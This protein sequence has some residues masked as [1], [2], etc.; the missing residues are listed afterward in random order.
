MKVLIRSDLGEILRSI[1]D[2]RSPPFDQL[3]HYGSDSNQFAQLR[4]PNGKGPSPLL[5]VVH[6]G[7]WQSVYDL[8]HIGH[9]CAALTS[10]GVIT[11]SIEYRRIG[12][13]GGGWPGT[14]Q[15]ISLATRNILQKMSND[16]RFDGER[17]AIVGHSAG[18]HLALWLVGSHRISK[19]SQLHNDQRQDIGGAVSLAGLSDLRLAWN[20]KLGRGIVTR[21]IGGTPDEHP[22]RYDAGSPIELLPTGS[23][24]VL[25]HG[26]D[27]DTVPIS[28][29][30]AFVEKAEKLGD[31]SS[32]VRLE[33]VGH[34]ELIDPESAAWPAV[35]R[36]ILSLFDV[37]RHH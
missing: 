31:Q 16:S 8:S 9:L 29:S 11:C 12:N 3:V 4:F 36:A 18:G 13:L 23:R 34:Y 35:V 30:E 26:T 5:F 17:T 22:D 25:V 15:D 21:L 2:R 7:F 19:T 27:D 6:G 37:D 32:L 24:H 1:L 28:Q 20:Q 33:G 14:F 10:E